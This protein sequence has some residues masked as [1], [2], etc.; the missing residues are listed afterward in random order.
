[1]DY[2]CLNAAIEI[3]KLSYYAAELIIRFH[4]IFLNDMALMNQTEAHLGRFIK[5]SA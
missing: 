1:M 2:I 3:S 5:S 4:P